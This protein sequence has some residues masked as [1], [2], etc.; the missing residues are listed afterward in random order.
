[1][2]GDQL[3]HTNSKCKSPAAGIE[4]AVEYSLSYTLNFGSDPTLPQD[5]IKKVEYCLNE[6]EI[7][8]LISYIKKNNITANASMQETYC[9]IKYIIKDSKIL[10]AHLLDHVMERDG[11]A[12][13]NSALPRRAKSFS[14]V[15]IHSDGK[16]FSSAGSV[17][18]ICADHPPYKKG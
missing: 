7:K 6:N 12:P 4:V 11:L 3:M 17:R 16:K 8:P 10:C 18:E 2:L 9:T 1:M 14:V 15:R 13:P 5:N